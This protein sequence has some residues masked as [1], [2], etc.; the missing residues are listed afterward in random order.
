MGTGA[1][2]CALCDLGRWGSSPGNCSY[3]AVGKFQDDKGAKDCKDCR[4]DR[5]GVELE[6][7]KKGAVSAAECE[8]CEA[9][10]A[11]EAVD[12]GRDMWSIEFFLCTCAGVAMARRSARAAGAR[13]RGEAEIFALR[14]RRG[15]CA[16]CGVGECAK[17]GGAHRRAEEVA[18]G[19]RE[20]GVHG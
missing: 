1:A 14:D 18:V 19:H 4:Q 20:V 8:A 17:R 2:A 16:A 3:C 9:G 6:G 15:E 11:I 7:G 13:C 10:R 5:F 12:A